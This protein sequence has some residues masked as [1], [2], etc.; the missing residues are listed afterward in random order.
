LDFFQEPGY[1]FVIPVK[2][3]QGIEQLHNAL[4]FE[5][6]LCLMKTLQEKAN[7]F[8]FWKVFELG[9]L[10]LFDVEMMEVAKE[11]VEELFFTKIGFDENAPLLGVAALIQNLRPQ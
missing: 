11:D 3:R 5:G 4:S 10:L 6:D 2:G 7:G 1:F 8:E 9:F